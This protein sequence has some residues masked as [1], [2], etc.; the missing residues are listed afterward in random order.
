MWDL[1]SCW[2]RERSR[3]ERE[4]ACAPRNR[5]GPRTRDLEIGL[6]SG[7]CG[8]SPASLALLARS[9]R[10]IGAQYRYTRRLLQRGRSRRRFEQVPTARDRWRLRYCAGGA[11]VRRAQN[12][13][14]S[15]LQLLMSL[16]MHVD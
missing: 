14:L 2:K 8:P 6:Y 1:E 5:R 11:T 3:C 13:E 7:L 12:S 9:S 16:R 15:P 4:R 10:D